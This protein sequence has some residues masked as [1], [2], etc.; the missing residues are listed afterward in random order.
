[1]AKYRG[2]R[3]YHV[4]VVL[5]TGKKNKGNYYK[6]PRSA[7]NKRVE[8]LTKLTEDYQVAMRYVPTG[9]IASQNRGYVKMLPVPMRLAA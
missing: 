3:P 6:S 4:F 9:H 2:P 5:P 7:W 1:M 8:L